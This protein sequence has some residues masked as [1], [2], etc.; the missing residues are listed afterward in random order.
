MSYPDEVWNEAMRRHG[1]RVS[2]F[3][4]LT[5]DVDGMP[6]GVA[7]RHVR[8]FVIDREEMQTIAR[9]LGLPKGTEQ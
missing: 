1:H 8:G 5:E 6:L 2:T 7:E 3:H 4:E 9:E